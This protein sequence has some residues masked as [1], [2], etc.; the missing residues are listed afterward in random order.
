MN[1]SNLNT[2]LKTLGEAWVT[3]NPE[4]IGSVCAEDVKYYENPFEEPRVGRDAVIAE[5]QNVPNTQKDITF[6]YDIIGIV[7]G[8]GI[9]H[10]R[11]S[12]TRITENRQDTLDGIFTVQLNDSGLCTEFHM[13][14]VTK[15]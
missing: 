11:A 1:E 10:W 14:W 2:W 4:L 8:T 7:N 12:F 3:K 9:A 13:W 5:W 6:D 15:D